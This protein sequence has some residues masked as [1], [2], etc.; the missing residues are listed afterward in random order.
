[1]LKQ[2]IPT[3]VLT[4]I[5]AVAVLVAGFFLWR[6]YAAPPTMPAEL[7]APSYQGTAAQKME[8]LRRTQAF[9]AQQEAAAR[10]RAPR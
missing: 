2:P 9:E 1:M 10:G 5:I 6:Q 4:A 3:P 7:A 8:M